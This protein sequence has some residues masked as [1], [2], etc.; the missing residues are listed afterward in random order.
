MQSKD[1]GAWLMGG[2][3][4]SWAWTYLN[5]GI[6][7]C[8]VEIQLLLMKNFS[9]IHQD[10]PVRIHGLGWKPLNGLILDGLQNGCQERHF[11]DQNCIKAKINFSLT[12]HQ[13]RR[14]VNNVS[15]NWGGLLMRSLPLD[16]GNIFA[17]NLSF[18]AKSVSE[19]V[20]GQFW[21]NSFG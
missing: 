8:L 19:E 9:N 16:G 6:L 7:H 21:I 10:T 4:S 1:C 15:G 20:G 11:T 3:G 14:N 18:S 5:W 2:L 13:L 12:I 17:K